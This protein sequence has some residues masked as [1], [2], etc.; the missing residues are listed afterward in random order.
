VAPSS[1]Q[2][3][4]RTGGRNSCRTPGFSTASV[5]ALP[6]STRPPRFFADLGLEVEGRT[7]LEGSFVDDVV[8]I[9]DARTEIVVL[10][11]P[12]GGTGVELAR[13]C[14]PAHVPG[15]PT[16][17]A[18][19]RFTDAAAEEL[20]LRPDTVWGPSRPRSVVMSM[21]RSVS[22]SAWCENPSEAHGVRTPAKRMV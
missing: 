19:E 16:A 4:E 5:S 7:F 22:S 6:T 11:P 13:S 1:D 8:G 17:M 9:P 2:S 15:M 12:G 10:R 18:N 20:W 21:R 3:A 14:A